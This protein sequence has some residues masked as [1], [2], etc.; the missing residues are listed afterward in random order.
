MRNRRFASSAGIATLLMASARTFLVHD[1]MYYKGKPDTRRAAL[2]ASN[3]VYEYKI[4]PNKADASVP[5]RIA[6]CWW[7]WSERWRVIRAL[8]SWMW[9]ACPGE[10]LGRWPSGIWMHWPHWQ[11]ARMKRAEEIGGILGNENALESF[12]SKPSFGT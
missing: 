9:R 11:I 3:I 5:C 1:N 4:W 10:G 7:R 8:W 2:L 6:V 12:R